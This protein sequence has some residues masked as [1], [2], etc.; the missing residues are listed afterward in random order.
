MI[1]LW[2]TYRILYRCLL[3]PRTGPHIRQ[4]VINEDGTGT[5]VLYAFAMTAAGIIPSAT[6]TFDGVT[7]NEFR[8]VVGTGGTQPTIPTSFMDTVRIGNVSGNVFGD[9][10][11]SQNS[12]DR[13]AISAATSLSAGSTLFNGTAIGVRVEVR[14]VAN[15]AI[16][17]SNFAPATFRFGTPI[18]PT[19]D[20]ARVNATQLSINGR[21]RVTSTH[22]LSGPV[23]F[24][25]Q[26]QAHSW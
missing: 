26:T 8:V 13:I 18:N 22:T 6:I 4:I 21:V 2:T 3:G 15:N 9:T 1:I 11:I 12:F 17:F 10:M 7:S 14:S 25:R 24:S 20:E 5:L 16:L 19:W 23:A